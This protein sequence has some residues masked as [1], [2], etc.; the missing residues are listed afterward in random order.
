MR[1]N[2]KAAEAA[3]NDA[4]RASVGEDAP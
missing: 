3:A 1:G 2:A 4:E